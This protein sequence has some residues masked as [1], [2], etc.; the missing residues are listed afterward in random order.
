MLKC[1]LEEGDFV[2]KPT[3]TPAKTPLTMLSR[4]EA[5][6]LAGVSVSVLDKAISEGILKTRQVTANGRKQTLVPRESVVAICLLQSVRR[7][8]FEMS[9]K[10]KKRL[11][12][13]LGLWPFDRSPAGTSLRTDAKIEIEV[14]PTVVV[15]PDE[16][17]LAAAERTE[18]YTEAR[19]RW[20]ERNPRIFGG[21]AVITGT[22]ITAHAIARRLEDG[23]TIETL[24]E[25]YPYLPRAAFE[26]ADTYAK[27][28]P[29]RGRP[30]KPWR[31][32][33]PA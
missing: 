11:V 31:G 14:S 15:R 4:N 12:D 23:D 20:I 18:R 1:N 10:S 13:S 32:P 25:D 21:E 24:L 17:T 8:G 7:A 9:V 5:S 30:A 29:R 33:A 22:R 26:V 19:N 16:L 27:A 28:H 3:S 6:V 2:R